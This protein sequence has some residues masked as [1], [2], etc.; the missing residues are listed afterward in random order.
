VEAISHFTKGLEL[1]KTL[2]DTR[3]RAQQEL[4]LQLA[5]GAPF[6]ATKGYAAR[7][8]GKAYTRAR[9]LCQQLGETPQ[10]FSALWG[11]CA[12][13][14]VRAEYRTARELAEQMLRLAQ[15][16]QDQNLLMEAHAVLGIILFYLGELA[17]ARAHLEQRIALD[18]PL[19]HHTLTILYGGVDP[20]VHCLSYTIA[21]LWL[22][23]YPTQALKMSHETLT[24]ARELSHPFSL[25]TTLCWVTMLHQFRREEQTVQ[26]R[27]EAMITLCG[28]KE[29]AG[30]SL[31]GVA[32]QGWALAE[33]RQGEKGIAQI[34][35]SLTAWQ[36][37][38]RAGMQTYALALLA[39]AHG[40]TGQA[41]EGLSTLA[42][43]LVVVSKTE[44]R[45]YE[46]ELYRL[47][48]QLTLQQFQVS[49]FKFQLMVRSN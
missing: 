17:L 36:T 22:L 47:K 41:E 35:Q 26:E 25:A 2:P 5:L 28:E 45:W 31:W 8:A 42:E 3:E 4:T 37:V 11:L 15:N 7:E 16:V 6:I 23:G 32:L 33:Q 13:H 49:G 38:G 44:E 12:F 24:L 21:T 14:T 46:A 34:R 43:A 48:G 9:E 18:D 20:G 19:Q 40:R 27:A 10:L 30:G 29:I 39:E 1:L